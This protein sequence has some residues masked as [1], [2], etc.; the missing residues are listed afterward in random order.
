MEELEIPTRMPNLLNKDLGEIDPE[1]LEHVA[2]EVAIMLR[3]IEKPRANLGSS[4]P[5]GRVD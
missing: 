3:G 2:P 5:P 4:G 1:F